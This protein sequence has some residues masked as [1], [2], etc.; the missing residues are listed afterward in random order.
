MT[1]TIQNLERKYKP[2]P[3][4]TLA[5]R[6]IDW[7]KT[8]NENLKFALDVLELHHNPEVSEVLFEIQTRICEGRWLDTEN[9]PPPLAN[10]PFWLKIYPFSLLWK[11]R[12]R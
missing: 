6:E 5:R 9:P 2:A 12:P 7:T 11:Q 1:T 4:T 3:G 8:S 10:M